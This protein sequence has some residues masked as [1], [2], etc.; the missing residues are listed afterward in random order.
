[1]WVWKGEAPN[2]AV[3]RVKQT[4]L[5]ARVLCHPYPAIDWAKATRCIV[6]VIRAPDEIKIRFLH[7][8]WQLSLPDMVRQS[9]SRDGNNFGEPNADVVKFFAFLSARTSSF[10]G[11]AGSSKA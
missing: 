9:P 5:L 11:V 3:A 8:V 4:V 2:T 7:G 1:M 10:P 6:K